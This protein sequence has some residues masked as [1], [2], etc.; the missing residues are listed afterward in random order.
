MF[1]NILNVYNIFYNFFRHQKQ[2]FEHNLPWV[3]KQA[4]QSRFL[5]ALNWEERF[6]QPITDLQKECSIEPFLLNK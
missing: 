5:L 2:F 6:E 3:L 4:Q 1:K